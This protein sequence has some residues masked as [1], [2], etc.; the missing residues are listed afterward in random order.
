M[1]K[2]DKK[3]WFR[4]YLITDAEKRLKTPFS[5]LPD[6][7]RTVEMT[8]FYIKS[9]VSKLTPGLVPDDEQ[10]IDDYIVDGAGD[11]GVDF[12][13]PSEGRVLIVQSKYHGSEKHENQEDLTHF[14]EVLVRL[15]DAYKKKQKLNRKVTE[16]LIDI[17]WES[18]YFELHFITLGK[19]SKTLRDRAAKGPAAVKGLPNLEDRADLSLFDEQELNIKLREAL[20]ASEVLDQSI[21]IKFAPNPDGVPWIRLESSGGRDLVCG[22]SGWYAIG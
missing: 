21:E 11:G 3:P 15:F 5:S 2:A 18:D 22:P 4:D 9:V 17:D 20:S 7:I 13:Y 1:E 12:I 14:C 19:V 8:R 10:E 16:A 6:K